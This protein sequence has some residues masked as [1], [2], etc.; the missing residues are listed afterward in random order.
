MILEGLNL[1]SICPRSA[2]HLRRTPS[3][4][5]DLPSI[6]PSGVQLLIRICPGSAQ[7]PPRICPAHAQKPVLRSSYHVLCSSAALRAASATSHSDF[8]RVWICSA[9]ASAQDLPPKLCLGSAQQLSKWIYPPSAQLL[10]SI[11]PNTCP[12]SAQDL[13]SICTGSVQELPNICPAPA[14]HL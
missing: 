2:K 9:S 1:P 11:C 13:P 8:R 7:A 14:Q 10:I 6:C 5:W 12:G 4:A 3:S